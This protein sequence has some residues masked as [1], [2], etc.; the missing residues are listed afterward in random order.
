MTRWYVYVKTPIREGARFMAWAADSPAS[1]DANAALFP[2][3]VYF[4]FGDTAL[5]A[6][7]KLEAE[8]P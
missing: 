7:T 8:L 6:L 3:E 1:P 5:E 4:T 2:G